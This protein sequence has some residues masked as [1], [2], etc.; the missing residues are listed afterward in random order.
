LRHVIGFLIASAVQAGI[1]WIA[2]AMRFSVL[3]P[4]FTANQ[5]LI[6]FLVGQAA[7]LVLLAFQRIVTVIKDTGPW[8]L[9]IVFGGIFWALALPFAASRG[10]V[11]WPWTA[12]VSTILWTLVAFLAYGVIAA[13]AVKPVERRIRT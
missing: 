3:G 9:G 4:G 12:G 11:R 2:E 5:L 6:H 10:M 13:F 1:I 8:P 7:G